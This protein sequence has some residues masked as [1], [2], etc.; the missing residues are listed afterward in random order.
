VNTPA[1]PHAGT[2]PADVVRAAAQ[3]LWELRLEDPYTRASNGLQ[4]TSLPSGSL[5]EAEA[6]AARARAIAQTLEAVVADQ[7]S[8]TTR[9]TLEVL[10]E[11][12][13]QQARQPRAWWTTSPVTPY[14]SYHFSYYAQQIIGSGVPSSAEELERR[15]GLW[16]DLAQALRTARR[17][18]DAQ[19]SQG[20]RLARPA[21]APTAAAWRALRAALGERLCVQSSSGANPAGAARWQQSAAR[22][23]DHEVLPA[24]D[25]VLAAL[26]DAD[27]AARA[28]EHAGLCHLP[29]GD[30]VYGEL[31]RAH[32]TMEDS[33]QRL[34]DS[35]HEELRHLG[36]R[37]RAVRQHIGFTGS[38]AD[39]HQALKRDPRVIATSADEVAQRYQRCLE[40]IQPLL[41]A[42]FS[43]LP[44]SP[45]KTQRL[46]PEQEA[47][48]T[49]G[50]YDKPHR[51]GDEGVYR[52][53][54]SNLA[55]RS[56]LQVASL[57]YH[58]L[59]P[60]HHFHLAL[61]MEHEHLPPIRRTSTEWSVFNEGWAEYASGLA[62]EMG[63]YDD[64]YDLY[65]RLV[66]ES[67]IAQRLVVDTGLNALGWTLERAR[68]FM[69]QHTL[70][71]AAQV[72][73]ETLRYATDMPAQALAYRTGYRW[74]M[75]LRRDAEQRLGPAFDIRRFHEVLLEEGAL[76]IA[77]L[78][79]HVE[80]ALYGA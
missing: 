16:S 5:E 45:C 3:S 72:A 24:A 33:P 12:L 22:L 20:W 49:Y 59:L 73:S 42:W 80:R 4:V 57:V 46:A 71:G 41:P 74:F 68:A 70:E 60:G 79:G 36:E 27:Y 51:V 18:L 14:A 2:D 30:A 44:K 58:E 53:N 6:D 56:Q 28:P 54:A 11:A 76:P 69:H 7:L 21:L 31:I 25:D 66:H 75:D 52:F 50:Y 8:E 1:Q 29:G 65:G 19:A 61:Q 62:E 47:G 17:R 15:C 37:M 43:R 34:H 23:R 10:R 38:A 67:F 26:E 78:R 32:L 9:L 35:G 48:M 13:A 39:F 40:R 64:P 63:L 77:A 55:E